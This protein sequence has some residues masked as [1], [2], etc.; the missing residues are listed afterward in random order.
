MR[1]MQRLNAK[2]TGPD[3]AT[4]I[5]FAHGFGC[6]QNMWRLVAPAFEQDF[7]VVTFDHVG[8]GGSDLGA[9]DPQT[10]SSLGGYAA[11]VIDLVDELDLG[12]VVFVGHSV[13]SMIGVLAA[14][15]R[16]DLFDR[17]VLVGPSAR[18]IDDGDYVGGF[19]AA[20]ID[21]LLES[22]DS[23][24][25]GW[26]HGMAP[27]IMGNSDRPELADELDQSFC[28]TDPDIARRFAEVT[29]RS[30][31]R[32]DLA[33]VSAPTLVLQCR[34]DVIAPMSAGEYVRDRLPDAT[35]LVLDA[36]GHCPHLSAPAATTDAIATF[37]GARVLGA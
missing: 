28:R 37:L 36:V 29:F 1:A 16:P 24:Y 25:L 32:D 35:F 27:A 9:Y 10:Y 14:V 5:V 11:D 12:P 2:V 13:S 18:Y 26:S 20:D 23:N 7:C 17:L 19:S 8:A 15:E 3:G 33:K 4:V 22:M 31:N 21:E 30:D 34:E 6:D